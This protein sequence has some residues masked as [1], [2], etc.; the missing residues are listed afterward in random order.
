MEN[1]CKVKEKMK[2]RERKRREG[3]K[4]GGKEAREKEDTLH[5]QRHSEIQTPHSD[6]ISLTGEIHT[7]K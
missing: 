2:E 6:S 3:E 7:T 5:H 1:E 4:E